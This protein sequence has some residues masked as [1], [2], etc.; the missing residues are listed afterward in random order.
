MAKVGDA[1][2]EETRSDIIEKFSQGKLV[3]EIMK[4]INLSRSEIKDVIEDYLNAKMLSE[5]KRI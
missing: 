4:E 1:L 2:S 3:S 5:D